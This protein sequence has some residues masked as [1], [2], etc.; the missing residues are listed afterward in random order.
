MRLVCVREATVRVPRPSAEDAS[1]T[2][3][4]GEFIITEYSH[5]YTEQN[6]HQ[7]ADRTGWRV[8]RRWTDPNQWFTVWLLKAAPD[9]ATP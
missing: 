3:Q 4:P 8:D 5:K 2:F 9:F 6:V 7:L 1:F